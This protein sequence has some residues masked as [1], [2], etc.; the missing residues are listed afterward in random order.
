MK[1]LPI[2][3]SAMTLMCAAPPTAI[4]DFESKRPKADENGVPLFTV[5]LVV[6]H[7]G[8]AE[9]MLVRVAGSPA[10][11]PGAGHSRPGRRAGR[12]TV[13]NGRPIRGVVPGRPDRTD[14]ACV[15]VVDRCRQ[16]GSHW[17]GGK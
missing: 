14:R 12:D 5:Q 15:I 13:G 8:G 7:D 16:R 6:L 17:P 1:N 10:G 9:I 2:D 11:V 4:V 3:T